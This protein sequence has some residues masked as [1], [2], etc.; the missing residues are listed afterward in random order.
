MKAFI[1]SYFGYCPL[2]WM[3]HSK[4]LNHRINKL[5]KRALSIVYQDNESS[6]EELLAK[7][8][9]FTI[10]ERNIQTL[11]IELYK[12]W[13]GQS[14]KI[15]ELVLPL[16]EITKYSKQKSFYFRK[17]KS[18]YNGTETIAYL[19]PRIWSLVPEDW[20]DLHLLEFSRKIRKWRT[21]KCPCRICKVYIQG[22]GFIG[23]V[24]A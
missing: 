19:G 22:V 23:K 6:F 11:A 16:N 1:S 20:K 14:P 3:F 12:V 15:M 4:K 8:E 13:H 10:H 9:S 21:E 7:N 5:H 18:V 17:V 2:V 24:S